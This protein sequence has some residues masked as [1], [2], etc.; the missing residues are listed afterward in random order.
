V[1]ISLDGS[2]ATSSRRV[3]VLSTLTAPLLPRQLAALYD[4]G[5]DELFVICDS[6]GFSE[7]DRRIWQE[8]TGGTF[9]AS[10]SRL[11]D[12]ARQQL[13]F[14]FVENHNDSNCL[15]LI[16]SLRLTVAIN[17]GTPRRL[18]SEVLSATERGVIN[19]HPGVLPKYRGSSCVEWAIFN[20]DA[21]GN[22][23]HFM[24]EGYD[25]GPIIESESYRFDA[26]DTYQS[27]RVRVYREAL[28]MMAQA[29]KRVLDDGLTVDR[30]EPQG[31][32]ELF[33]PIPPEKMLVVMSKIEAGTYRFMT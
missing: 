16:K 17:A 18:S 27:I 8:R 12:F 14:F 10:D 13:P 7:R 29:V 15:Q 28:R 26:H 21:V 6:K 11:S 9:D 4:A 19:V 33:K 22:T 30:A 23:A 5:I 3:G 25:E 20:D 31:P 32:G 24:V 2:I 1:I